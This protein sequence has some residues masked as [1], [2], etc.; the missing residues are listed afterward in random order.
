[1]RN[2]S[3]EREGPCCVGPGT[4]GA[5]RVWWDPQGR[6]D[7]EFCLTHGKGEWLLALAIYQT[8]VE[9]SVTLSVF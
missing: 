1:M 8:R 4:Q 9:D 6:V 3:K 2:V 5:L 7:V